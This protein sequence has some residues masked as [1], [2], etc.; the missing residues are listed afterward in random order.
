MHLGTAAL[1]DLAQQMTEA[2]EDRHQHTLPWLDQRDQHRLDTG[3]RGAIDQQ[4]GIIG[5]LEDAAIELHR[6]VHVVRHR[7]VVLADQ[8]SGKRSQYTRVRIDRTGAHQQALG[9]MN[10]VKG[11][12]HGR[13]SCSRA[14][15]AERL[16]NSPSLMP[17][18]L[19]QVRQNFI[20][21]TNVELPVYLTGA[22]SLSWRGHRGAKGNQATRQPD[23][24][25]TERHL[26]KRR[27]GSKITL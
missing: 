17:R 7:R 22:P 5:G 15:N 24:R 23:N 1:G 13:S 11:R 12:A 16:A 14:W 20:N 9:R 19:Q 4:G 8:G 25:V 27:H 3:T 6:L 21:E 2:A 18:L 10:L 26:G